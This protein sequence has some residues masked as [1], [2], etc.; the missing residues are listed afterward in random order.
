MP[1]DILDPRGTWDDESEYDAMADKLALMFASNF[2]KF[3]A[4]CSDEVLAAAP[5]PL[6]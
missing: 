1:D 3:A 5:T 2:D 6:G 4:G